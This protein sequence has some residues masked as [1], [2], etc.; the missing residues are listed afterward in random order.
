MNLGKHT[1]SKAERLCKKKTINSLFESSGN[2][3]MLEYPFLFVWREINE[4]PSITVKVMISVGKKY[5]KKATVRNR[6]K[7]QIRELFRLSKNPLYQTL[8]S[9]NKQIALM[10]LFIGK[11]EYTYAQLK[12][13]F[14]KIIEKLDQHYH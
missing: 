10:I 11:E 9:Q 2:N 1:F 3:K 6:I 13:S 8:K 12:Q 7:R 14:D 4:T 5:S